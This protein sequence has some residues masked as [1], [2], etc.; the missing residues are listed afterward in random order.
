MSRA[1][2]LAGLARFAEISALLLNATK[3]RCAI[4][5]QPG[6]PGKPGS[7]YRDAGIPASRAEICPYHVIGFAGPARLTV[8]AFSRT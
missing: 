7:W 8:P 2:R 1:T 4:T 3:I 6:Q 5:C